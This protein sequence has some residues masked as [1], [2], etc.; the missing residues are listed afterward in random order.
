MN[1]SVLQ[2]VNNNVNIYKQQ[3]SF[4]E[5][6]SHELQ[7]PI[8]LLKSKMDLLIQQTGVSPEVTEL[9]SSIEAPLS[10]LSRINK[11]L[12]LLAKIE[13]QQ[14]GE[15]EQLDIKEYLETAIDLFDDY[16]TDKQLKLSNNIKGP[17]LVNANSF[18]LET[19][20]HNLLSN[21]IRHTAK[22]GTIDISREGKV[23]QIRNQ[24]KESLDENQLFERF[25][26]SSR[27]KVSSGLGL[28]IVHE[29]AKKF[30]WHVSYRFENGF[31]AFTVDFE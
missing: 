1:Q 23:I 11:N 17:L 2:M 25:A 21:A 15:Q 16:L 9:L 3:K 26:A 19:L 18:L 20:L 8:A 6:A 30:G 28:A 4:I 22:Y 7:T 29:I 27:D 5:N 10:R 12:L 14:F 31:H 24:G 13:N